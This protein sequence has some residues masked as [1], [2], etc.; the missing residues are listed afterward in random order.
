MPL[1]YPKAEKEKSER[2]ETPKPH[3]IA[4]YRSTKT[5]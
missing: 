1:L 5:R 4:I 3:I 2:A